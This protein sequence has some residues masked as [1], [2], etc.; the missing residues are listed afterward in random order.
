MISELWKEAGGTITTFDGYDQREDNLEVVSF[1]R[2]AELLGL[3][4]LSSGLVRCR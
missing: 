2:T 4:V 1:W 3:A